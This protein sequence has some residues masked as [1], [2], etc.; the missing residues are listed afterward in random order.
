MKKYLFL[1]VASLIIVAPS[2]LGECICG[3]RCCHG[4]I[5]TPGMQEIQGACHIFPGK[6]TEK[7]DCNRIPVPGAYWG[8]TYQGDADWVCT[9][10]TE[11]ER[12][13]KSK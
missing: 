10:C 6:Y 4:T 13:A 8:D 11:S 9:G 7:I 1:F 2:L 3:W 12:I 5:D